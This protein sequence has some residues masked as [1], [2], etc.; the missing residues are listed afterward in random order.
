MS[1]PF[2]DRMSFIIRCRIWYTLRCKCFWCM[3]A[4]HGNFFFK[5]RAS[6]G[7]LP[8]IR[9]GIPDIKP[10]EGTN[11]R[12][13]SDWAFLGGVFSLNLT[14]KSINMRRICYLVLFTCASFNVP[15][16]TQTQ[17]TTDF[18]NW[19]FS[20]DLEHYV[21]DHEILMIPKIEVVLDLKC[22]FLH[23]KLKTRFFVSLLWREN[24]Q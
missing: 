13:R 14:F 16:F 18:N 21:Y 1:G 6:T 3:L 23:T 2:K 7:D 15:C 4:I 9:F 12:V 20:N 24:V 19:M 22:N 8:Q 5:R 17:T 10:K 11:K